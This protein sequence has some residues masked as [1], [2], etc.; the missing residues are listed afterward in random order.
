MYPFIINRKAKS[1]RAKRVKVEANSYEEALN[2]VLA[3]NPGKWVTTTYARNLIVVD[4]S[5]AEKAALQSK[6]T[7]PKIGRIY[8]KPFKHITNTMDLITAKVDAAALS[9]KKGKK[10]YINVDSEG[11]CII[12]SLPA[13]KQEDIMA[14]F[15]AGNEVKLEDHVTM[16]VDEVKTSASQPATKKTKE[17]VKK[18]K[19]KKVKTMATVKTAVKKTAKKVAKKVTKKTAPAKKDTREIKIPR[20]N[21]MFLTEA[22]WK[23]VDALLAKEGLTFSAWSRSLVE[24]KIK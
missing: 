1:L 20:G 7:I 21:N 2:K 10:L 4:F 12:E 13:K 22:Q 9:R 18:E 23:K 17:V 11:E 24:V 3:V 8:C 15:I 14:V 16:V 5:I 19:T 6:T